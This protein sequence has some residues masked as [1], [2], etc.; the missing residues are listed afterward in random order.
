MAQ[1]QNREQNVVLRAAS[2]EPAAAQGGG[3]PARLTESLSDMLVRSPAPDGSPS[4]EPAG[5]YRII[6]GN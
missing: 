3:S 4:R 6:S 1:K 2:A 5:T